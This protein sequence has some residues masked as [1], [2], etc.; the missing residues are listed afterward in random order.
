MRLKITTYRWLD[1]TALS[2]TAVLFYTILIPVFSILSN[3][4]YELLDLLHWTI[5]LAISLLMT[6]VVWFILHSLGG[7]YFRCFLYNPPTWLSAIVSFVIC[8]FVYLYL[9]E[10]NYPK[11]TGVVSI[12]L[13]IVLIIFVTGG[14]LA[15]IINIIF[16][17][18]ETGLKDIGLRTGLDGKS[19]DMTELTENIEELIS[20]LHKEE[21]ILSPSQDC[22]NMSV[23]AR[24]ITRILKSTPLKTIGLVGPYGCGKSS[25]IQMVQHYID[26]PCDFTDGQDIKASQ[27]KSESSK[28]ITCLVSSWGFREDTATKHILHAAIKELSK[29]TDCIGLQNLPEHYRR[30]MVD[31]GNFLAKILSTIL[32]GWR[33]PLSVLRRL[34]VVLGGIGKRL[35]IF[36]EDIDR[37]KRSDV[38][39]NE[40][41]TLLDGLKGL[42]HISFVVVIGD[43]YREEE[44]IIKVSE[45]IEV[46]PE[47][48][49][50]VTLKMLRTFRNHCLAMFPE[51]L[52]ALSN[53]DME[54][55]SG[56]DRSEMGDLFP[57]LVERMM[58]PIDNMVSLLRNP[59]ILKH[60]LRRTYEV[61]LK[62]HGE[63][64]FDELLACEIIQTSAVEIYLVI[65]S[66]ISTFRSLAQPNKNSEA[67]KRDDENQEK[68]KEIIDERTKGKSGD[69]S[70]AN[71]LIDFLFPG[72]NK[73]FFGHST[74]LLQSVSCES[75]TDY[76]RRIHL[77]EIGE[78]EIRD[79][80]IMQA[81]KAWRKNKETQV[82]KEFNLPKAIFE[83]E[84]FADK[85][86]Q[87]G[88]M[89]DGNEVRCL[90]TEL[91]R[92][93]LGEGEKIVKASRYLGF[94]QLWRLSLDNHVE[95][96]EHEKW[97]LNELRKALSV[98]LRFANDIYYYWRHQE[99]DTGRAD[100]TIELREQ[101][102]EAGK[103]IY[104]TNVELLIKVIDPDSF[105]CV[106]H[107]ARL[108][109]HQNQGGP[110]YKPEDWRWLGDVLVEAAVK[111]PSII[112]P[113]IAGLVVDSGDQFKSGKFVYPCEFNV[114]AAQKIFGTEGLN[115]IIPLLAKGRVNPE[116]DEQAKAMFECAISYAKK[117][118][119]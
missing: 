23:F 69:I 42:E 62:L 119:Q 29:Y 13:G 81:I 49:R 110:G 35:V 21:P 105:W 37:N 65:N 58:D 57:E 77:E 112:V 55:R 51:D 114:E 22:F 76:W 63:I 96:D 16:T 67:K 68:L 53:E 109:S 39:F 116:F 94:T 38:F 5:L 4:L 44:V 97:V 12:G 31:S 9:S 111:A 17:K 26:N 78:D 24:R 43:Q 95:K 20:W 8:T 87:F 28:I 75:A 40:I 102:V 66:N 98:S 59:R 74:K 19:L 115:K 86:E 7:V 15:Y 25:I 30:T 100:P 10:N 113:Q 48:G 85:I 91:F 11:N 47:L 82:Y 64:N 27:S 1:L 61:W 89:L 79:Q 117:E 90:S 41:S 118:I 92:L 52:D 80:T 32:G 3:N 54:K 33:S 46:V 93:I 84:G 6:S 34:D 50:K 14:A 73:D 108:F 72:W 107:F 45:H 106:H 56:F 71:S 104:S 99:R 88:T 18:F 2:I 70:A 103:E 60:A 83:V 101:F 36:L